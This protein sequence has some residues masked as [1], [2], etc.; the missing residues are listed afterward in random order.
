M[1]YSARKNEYKYVL[2][3]L[4]GTVIDSKAGILKCIKHALDN[5]SIP[6]PDEIL[7]QMVGPPFRVSMN[8]L[9]GVHDE[10]LI[11]ALIDEYRKEYDESGLYSST[12]YD[13]VENLLADLKNRGFVI[14]IATSKPYKFSKKIIDYLSLD[15]YFDFIGAASSDSS[16]EA[17][18]DVIEHV[19]ENLKVTDKSEVLMIGDRLYDIVGAKKVG[20]DSLA[21]LWGYGNEKEFEEYGAD[22][23]VKTPNEVFDFLTK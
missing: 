11:T 2:F 5:H 16:M 10:E 7:D 1:V 17:K 14:A 3:D 8:E 6:C 15:K 4:D 13:G 20:L 23:I 21:V 18:S 12:V 19:L 9:L 22:Y